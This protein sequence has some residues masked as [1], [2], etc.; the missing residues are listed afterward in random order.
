M[1]IQ[2]AVKE[3]T[4]QVSSPDSEDWVAL[5]RLGR[6]LVGKPRVVLKYDN[7]SI[8]R[9]I[10]CWVD[11]DWAGCQ[12]TRRS[13]SGGGLQYGTHTVETW[14]TTQPI[15]SLSSAESEYYGLVKG[16]C[17]LLGIVALF[18]DFGMSVQG[19]IH[20]DLSAAKGLSLIHI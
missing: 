11:A 9:Y 13:T 7:Q 14:S 19:R 17:Q 20:I 1:D 16:A 10:D 8:Q 12:R 15:V 2:Y 4:L 6:F 5:K 18:K 3:I